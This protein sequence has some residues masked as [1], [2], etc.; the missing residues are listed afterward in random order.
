MKEESHGLN[1]EVCE[2]CNISSKN[3]KEFVSVNCYSTNREIESGV[4]EN[5]V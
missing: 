5:A 3:C 1:T 2:N 4:P